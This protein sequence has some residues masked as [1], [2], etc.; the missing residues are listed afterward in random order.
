MLAPD[1]RREMDEHRD[2]IRGE[3]IRRIDP[4]VHELL[5]NAVPSGGNWFVG[6]VN[7]EAGGSMRISRKTGAWLDENDFGSKGDIFRLIERVRQCSFT[8]A[9]AW[10]ENF[11]AVAPLEID[12]KT[13]PV[14]VS[15]RSKI[16]TTPNDARQFL[17]QTILPTGTPGEKHLIERGFSATPYGVRFCPDASEPETGTRMPC[18]VFTYY[19]RAGKVSCVQRYYVTAEGKRAPLRYVKKAIGPAKGAVCKHNAASGKDVRLIAEGPTDGVAIGEM[20]RDVPAYSALAAGHL[21]EAP[22]WADCKSVYVL[23][24]REAAKTGEIAAELLRQRYAR[25]AP[26]TRV[27]VVLPPGDVKDWAD[28]LNAPDLGPSACRAALKAAMAQS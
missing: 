21:A 10:A 27:V 5:P 20:F 19:D 11:L 1:R 25:L 2:K 23:C 13:L 3:L 17:R 7:G 15:R 6:S 14:G 4:L 18:L 9:L 24:Q 8:E 16:E 22:V 12:P 28:A 26:E